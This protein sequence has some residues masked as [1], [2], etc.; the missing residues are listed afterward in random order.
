MSRLQLHLLRYITLKREQIVIETSARTA[1][2]I[3]SL[4]HA[5]VVVLILLF[6]SLFLFISIALGFA[7]L[8]KSYFLGF[9]SASGIYLIIAL[10]FA[11]LRQP[12]CRA[13]EEIL[14]PKM[15][16]TDRQG[17]YDERLRITKLLKVEKEQLKN[18]SPVD[19][20]E[21]VRPMAREATNL[22]LNYT[23]DQLSK[24]FFN[25]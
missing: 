23:I 24:R 21:L 13:V 12:F 7:L 14:L 5:A 15:T 11:L 19:I 9:L 16:D 17:V 6:A 2:A 18:P 10:I 8:F 1:Q 25:N 3:A 4:S 20:V 22:A